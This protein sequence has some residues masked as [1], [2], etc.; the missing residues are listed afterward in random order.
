MDDFHS[1]YAQG[2]VRVAACTPRC[3]V[4]DPVFNLG[5]TLALA[6]EAPTALTAAFAAHVR[7]FLPLA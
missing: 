1:I 2:F 5:E 4:A 6:R 7:K 3:A